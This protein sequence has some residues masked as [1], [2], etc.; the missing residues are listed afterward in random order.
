MDLS[1]ARGV[2]RTYITEAAFY[3]QTMRDERNPSTRLWL[4]TRAHKYRTLALI[5][6]RRMEE[7]R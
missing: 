4:A 7:V 3:A 6:A 1:T 5:A 2:F